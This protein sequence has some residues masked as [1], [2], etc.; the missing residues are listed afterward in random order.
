MKKVIFISAIALAAAVSCTKSE[1]VDTKFNEQ[2]GFETYLGRD[3]MT[4]GDVIEK[5]DL[6]SVK[7]FGYYHGDKTWAVS[8][9]LLW[10]QGLVLSAPAGVVAQPKDGDVRYWA[11]DLDNYTFLAYAPVGNSSLTE[12]EG[13][14]LNN[15]VLTYEVDSEDFTNADVLVAEPQIDRTRDKNG[16]VANLNGN[17]P[18]VL[19]HK[20]SRLIVKATAASAAFDFRVKEV[21]LTGNFYNSGKIALATPTA[22]SETTPEQT[23]Y[24]FFEYNK[25]NEVALSETEENVIGTKG[26]LMM[27]PV[28]ATNHKA[29]LTVKYTT[30]DPVA[31]QESREY[32]LTYN[33]TNDFA[34]G[35]AYA[36]KLAFS[37]DAIPISF[38]V[39]VDPTW[40]ND[41]DA[42]I[43]PA[44]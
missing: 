17:V 42:T 15:P 35:S 9:S 13:F 18:L 30:Y 40:G 39:E 4:K 26:Y 32:E 2:I 10:E 28:T 31:K 16:D 3:A 33:V 7:V 41:N 1:V 19:K 11:N 36:I 29:T 8:K 25:T 5:A 12:G 6:E 44:N 14:D 37:N 27:I 20:L 23:S 24:S 34:M 22:W 21:T 43:T 38:S